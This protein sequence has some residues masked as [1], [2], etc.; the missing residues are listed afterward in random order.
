MESRHLNLEGDF[1]IS[2]KGVV[3]P[4]V[5]LPRRDEL[6]GVRE[7]SGGGS[8]AFAALYSVAAPEGKEVPVPASLQ[9]ALVEL[10][11]H[12]V[13]RSLLPKGY[14]GVDLRFTPAG[15]AMIGEQQTSRAGMARLLEVAERISN[16]LT[17]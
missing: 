10:S 5:W 11:D 8:E 13:A 3:W 16:A 14:V 15:W 7:I 4:P 6:L 17:G 12:L 2:A 9:E 1:H